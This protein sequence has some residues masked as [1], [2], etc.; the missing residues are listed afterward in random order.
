MKFLTAVLK[1]IWG[2]FVDD[3]NLALQVL[4]LIGTLAIAVKRGGLSPLW[5]GGFLLVGCLAILAV[6]LSRRVQR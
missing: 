4:I 6:S 2:L 1:E 3:G 5:G